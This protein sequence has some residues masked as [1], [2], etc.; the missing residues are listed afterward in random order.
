MEH[1]IKR[2]YGK[3]VTIFELSDGRPYCVRIYN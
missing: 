2:D 1:V 3:F